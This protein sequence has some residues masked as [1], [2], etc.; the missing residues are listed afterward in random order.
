MT[1]AARGLGVALVIAAVA[2]YAMPHARG[3]QVG[4]RIAAVSLPSRHARAA[5]LSIKVQRVTE[6]LAR[7]EGATV[8]SDSTAV[9]VADTQAIFVRGQQ[10]AVDGKLDDAAELLD[11][12][13]ASAAQTPHRFASSTTVVDAHVVRAS[14]ALARGETDTADALIERVMRWDPTFALS[15]AE[16][17]PRLIAAVTRVRARVG[18]MPELRPEDLGGACALGDIV[19][20]RYLPDGSVDV[21]RYRDCRRTSQVRAPDASTL[22]LPTLGAPPL[23]APGTRADRPVWKRGWFW[24][25]A[26]IA[27]GATGVI[28]WQTADGSSDLVDV[29]PQL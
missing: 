8:A 10:L 21:S 13:L 27:V 18:E 20:A 19:V 2:L 29:V 11:G 9:D 6:S 24:I 16:R 7:A 17:T 3:D 15:D 5:T 25:A 14:I 4:A 1:R 23:S 28:V 12:A 22:V 26:G